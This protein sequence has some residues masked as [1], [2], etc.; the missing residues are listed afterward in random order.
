MCEKQRLLADIDQRLAEWEAEGDRLQ[1]ARREII[2]RN[3]LNKEPK[4]YTPSTPNS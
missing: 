4:C 3:D 2:N 1:E